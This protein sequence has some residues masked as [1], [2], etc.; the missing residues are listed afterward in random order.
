LATPSKKKVQVSPYPWQKKSAALVAVPSLGSQ[1]FQ[2]ISTPF[3][4]VSKFY[5][6]TSTVTCHRKEQK[7]E[8][9]SSRFR[10]FVKVSFHWGYH[11]RVPD[12]TSLRY[13]SFDGCHQYQ[14]YDRKRCLW[15]RYI[16]SLLGN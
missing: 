14:I 2:N 4:L 1:L 6:D 12:I 9:S 10:M 8:N 7:L 16:A 5:R 3:E 15:H 13:L 11:E